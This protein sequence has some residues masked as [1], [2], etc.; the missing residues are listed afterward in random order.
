MLALNLVVTLDDDTTKTFTCRTAEFIKFEEKFDMS[1]A[2]LKDDPRLTYLC[3]LA[4]LAAKRVEPVTVEFDA[5]A[6]SVKNIEA[7]S[8]KA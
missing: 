3:Y 7:D 2:K 8:P 4:W 5:W 6:E 1:F